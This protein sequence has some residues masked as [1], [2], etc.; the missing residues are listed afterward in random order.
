M[1]LLQEKSKSHVPFIDY[2]PAELKIT[3]SNGWQV[4]FYVRIPGSSKMKR[5]RRRIKKIKGHN[6]RNRY[7]RRICENINRKLDCGWS[8]LRD[9]SAK[10]EFKLFKEVLGKFLDQ[11]ER[12]LNDK[13]LRS[14]TLRSYRS[15]A[16]MFLKWLD[17]T[18]RTQLLTI[19][20]TKPLV[21]EFLDH[22]YF[23]KKRS[24]RTSNNYLAFLNQFGFFMVD[25]NFIS[26]NPISKIPSRKTNKKKREV[27]PSDVL[28]TIFEF[29]KEQNFSYYVLMLI[30]YCCFIRRTELTL[31]KVEHINLEGD[32]IFIPKE[33]AKNSKDAFVT[34]PRRL[35]KELAKHIDGAN[36][37]DY[38][39]SSSEFKTG[40][41]RLAPKKVSDEW[42]KTRNVLNFKKTYQF[43]SLKDTGI[44]TM[45]L[46]NIPTIKI[47]DQ[48][49]HHDIRVTETY[50][51]RLSKSDDTIADLMF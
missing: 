41:S 17:D 51:P 35:K 50:T 33:V 8:P 31:L 45:F 27:I 3:P 25:H 22:I 47:R 30:V 34:I 21:I 2:V 19:E 26:D 37:K 4:V 43:Y 10:N 32:T 13:V 36:N 1:Q 23:D 18:G 7:A 38:I 46:L 15:Y 5:Y 44:T 48:A 14:D 42:T 24:P 16:K 49:R 9:G 28:E 12:R 29:Q 11:A 6:A 40:T 39:F 20:F